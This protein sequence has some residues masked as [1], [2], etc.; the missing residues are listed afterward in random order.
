MFISLVYL[1]KYVAKVDFCTNFRTAFNA[2]YATFLLYLFCWFT[3]FSSYESK[4]L[5]SFEITCYVQSL[6]AK[7]PSPYVNGPWEKGHSEVQ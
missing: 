1:G 2:V 7:A 3:I 6:G 4:S 5:K